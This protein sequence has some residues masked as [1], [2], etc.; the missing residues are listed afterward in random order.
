MK[1]VICIILIF[2]CSQ[3]SGMMDFG[4]KAWFLNNSSDSKKKEELKK[5]ELK[6][7]IKNEKTPY[8]N[9]ADFEAAKNELEEANSLPQMLLYM[10]KEEIILPGH[11]YNE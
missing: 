1:Y 4:S 2:M 5:E 10:P 9:Q 8:I 7:N 3:I 11:K 6:K